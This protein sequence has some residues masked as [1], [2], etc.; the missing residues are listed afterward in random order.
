MIIATKEEL[1]NFEGKRLSIKFD[2]HG[3]STKEAEIS[4]TLSIPRLT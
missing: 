3:V 4:K 2:K 1:E